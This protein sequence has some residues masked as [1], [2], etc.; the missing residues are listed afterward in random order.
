MLSWL[1]SGTKLCPLPHHLV[2]ST[3]TIMKSLHSLK[4]A[5]NENHMKQK[6]Q[7]CFWIFILYSRIS[8]ESVH[9]NKINSDTLQNL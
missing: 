1:L 9:Q 6:Y 3:V 5:E 7:E 4:F 2:C 8:D